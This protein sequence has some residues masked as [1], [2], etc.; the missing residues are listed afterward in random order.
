MTDEAGL[1]LPARTG[2]AA[3]SEV[4]GLLVFM[5]TTQQEP[6]GVFLVAGLTGWARG[7]NTELIILILALGFQQKLRRNHRE[8]SGQQG[9]AVRPS[10]CSCIHFNIKAV[11]MPQIPHL[12]LPTGA[13]RS[14]QLRP[15]SQ[16]NRFKTAPHSR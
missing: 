7:D 12:E 3:E 4:K 14:L 16:A 1:P 6:L 11:V 8:V 5:L 10:S 2:P 13:S 9:A 15:M